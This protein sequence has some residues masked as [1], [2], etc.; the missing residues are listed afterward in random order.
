[1]GERRPR[2]PA[3][4]GAPRGITR[5]QAAAWLCMRPA[6][7]DAYVKQGLLPAALPWEVWDLK[8]LELAVDTISG[9]AEPSKRDWSAIARG[10]CHGGDPV[11]VR[12][13]PSKR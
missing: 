3:S 8:A 5:E 11:A 1:M 9:L 10:R 13:A 4:F 2:L 6:D 7:F 12:H